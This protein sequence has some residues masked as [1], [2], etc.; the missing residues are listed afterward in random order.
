M[1]SGL[2]IGLPVFFQV[3]LVLLAPVLFTAQRQSRMS[4]LRLGLPMVAG[5]SAA[6]GL[7]PPHPGPI[8]AIE[9]LGA[10]PGR[11]LF[12]SLI[13]ALP[14]SIISGPFYARYICRRVEVEPGPMAEQFTNVALP[15]RTPSLGLTLVTMLMPVLLMLLA[16][17]A[18]I[19]MADGTPRR[20]I[21]F[22]GSPLVAM[23]V[24]T[25][26]AFVTFG[27]S[28]RFSRVRLLEFAEQSL[29]PIAGVLLVV[30]AG[31]GFRPRARHRA[32]R[33]RHCPGDG[34]SPVVAA[35]DGLGDRVPA[36][37]V[38][39]LGH[40]VGDHR[41]QHHGAARRLAFRR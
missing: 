40:G 13:L 22:I 15:A 31:G 18:Q 37:F 21:S 1:L 24:A 34:W 38:G 36:A 26:A 17:A 3:G 20:V 7:V 33:R 30:G 8:A 11:T 28:C 14:L 6:H 39:R 27:R 29:P 25:I 4:L 19:A 41:R 2:I 5:L 12:Y 16:S 35:G 32:R 10:D 23:M 9:R